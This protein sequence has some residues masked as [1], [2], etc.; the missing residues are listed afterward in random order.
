MTETD[1]HAA[2]LS[3]GEDVCLHPLKSGSYLWCPFV[4]SRITLTLHHQWF[5]FDYIFT[6][7]VQC[8]GSLLADSRI[9]KNLPLTSGLKGYTLLDCMAFQHCHGSCHD[10][11]NSPA[12]SNSHVPGL[13]R[14]DSAIAEFTGFALICV[15]GTNVGL[16][17]I[18]S[19]LDHNRRQW[20][21]INK[22]SIKQNWQFWLCH[23]AL[24]QIFLTEKLHISSKQLTVQS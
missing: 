2:Q 13:A 12:P 21:G 3:L 4:K 18:L 24:I 5:Y 23:K 11:T 8:S 7:S 19:Y 6:N 17:G 14:F 22:F 16:N 9:C 1:Y 20:Q 10:V 15:S